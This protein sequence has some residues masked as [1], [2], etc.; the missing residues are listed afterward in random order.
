MMLV[1]TFRLQSNSLI[2]F[3]STQ[4]GSYLKQEEM[5]S[6][7]KHWKFYVR[8]KFNCSRELA[9]VALNIS[10]LEK[11]SRISSSVLH[12]I[13]PYSYFVIVDRLAK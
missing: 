7:I 11:K 5:F 13:S 1:T 6:I 9:S 12:Q 3:Y 8:L 10:A 4:G 2:W